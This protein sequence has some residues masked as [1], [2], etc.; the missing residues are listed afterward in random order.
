M[1]SDWQMPLVCC[2]IPLL[3]NLIILLDSY[4]VLASGFIGFRKIRLM[5]LIG[6]LQSAF[7]FVSY[8]VDDLKYFG[9][10]PAAVVIESLVYIIDSLFALGFCMLITEKYKAG[11]HR[12][13]SRKLLMVSPILICIVLELVNVFY[14]IIFVIDAE[15][16]EFSELP[17]AWLLYLASIGYIV[18]AAV[19][20]IKEWKEK[21]HYYNIPISLYFSIVAAGIIIEAIS[22]ELPLTPLCCSFAMMLIYSRILKRIGYI[23]NLSGLFTSAHISEHINSLTASKRKN[24]KIVAGILI[25]VNDFKSINDTYGHIVGDRAIRAI[26][27][28]LIQTTNNRW[29]CFRYGGDEFT[30]VGRVASESE[31]DEMKNNINAAVRRFNESKT[32][33]FTLSISQG[34]AVFDIENDS[35]VKF[36]ER[37]DAQMYIEKRKYHESK[38]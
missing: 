3:L 9:S 18:Y 11:I 8:M 14:P 26:S 7:Y 23:D 33:P 13:F 12:K 21:N 31:I 37:M 34:H 10:R 4:T 1:S 6:V 38:K 25:D 5:L 16:L 28:I 35:A 15:T 29:L 32:E 27:K 2:G 17:G 22:W 20:D 19:N 24:G 36:I 30:V